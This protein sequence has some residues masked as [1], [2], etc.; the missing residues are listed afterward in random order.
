MFISFFGIPQDIKYL[1]QF[2]YDD[3][4]QRN[5][6]QQRNFVDALLQLLDS[7]NVSA[8]R[9]TLELIGKILTEITVILSLNVF[10]RQ[11]VG[12]L[13]KTE[14][15]KIL[16]EM[17]SISNV[18]S[19]FVQNDMEVSN[20]TSVWL[21]TNENQQLPKYEQFINN[22]STLKMCCVLIDQQ[23]EST[24]NFG[25]ITMTFILQQLRNK[26]LLFST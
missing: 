20:R 25:I 14:N 7:Q 13:E 4:H 3:I 16:S 10:N 17:I 24:V 23:Q 6:Q 12:N 19:M 26:I 15:L 2:L 8:Q 21:N 1:S 22:Y 9:P 18:Y 11:V 5:G